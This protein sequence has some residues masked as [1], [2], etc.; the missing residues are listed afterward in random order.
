[1]ETAVISAID[2]NINHLLTKL[3]QEKVKST[4]KV[5]GKIITEELEILKNKFVVVHIDK[6]SDNVAFVCKNH[7]AQVLIN[8]LGL[9]NV[10][11]IATYMKATSE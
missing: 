8:E 11:N 10:N 3:Q 2:E 4:L 5:K 9:N 6:D 7:Y 1:M